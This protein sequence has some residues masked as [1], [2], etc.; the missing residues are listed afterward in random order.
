MPESPLAPEPYDLLLQGTV[1]L[2][3]VLTGLESPPS[4]GAEVL[5]SGMGSCPGGIANLAIAASRLGLRTTLSAAFGDDLY[6]DFCWT[7][8]A[9]QEGVDLSH[10]MRF[11]G[12]HSPVTVSMVLDRDRAMVTHAHPS[13]LPPTTMLGGRPAAAFGFVHLEAEPQPWVVEAAAGGMRL[14]ADVGWDPVEE[15]SPKILDQ[16]EH[17]YAFLPNSVE[18]MAYTRTDD[19]HD[20][21]HALADR[22][23]VA[24]VTC[25]GEGAIAMDATTGEEAW[26]PTFPVNAHDPTGAGDVFGAAFVLG[27]KYGWPLE[28]R[29]AFANLC[30]ALSVQN[31]GG[32]LAAPGWGDIV[33]WLAGIRGRAAAGSTTAADAVSRYA[34]LDDV[35]PDE[36][37]SVRRASATIARFSDA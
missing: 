22:V 21:V 25:G 12:W 24:V 3:V 18:A 20:A 31:V 6:A 13:P 32:S 35:V 33:D 15:W 19:P 29:L 23:P 37:A 5:A 34:F 36:H 8:L 27:T 7:T 2:D 30:A 4:R 10:S 14:F 9:E 26:V 16:L 28:R 1:F 11:P 17:Y